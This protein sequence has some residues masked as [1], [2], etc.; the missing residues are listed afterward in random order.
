MVVQSVDWTVVLWA[1]YLVDRLAEKSVEQMVVSKGERL[2]VWR[3][4]EW[5]VEMVA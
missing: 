5:V 2:V 4:V 3:V 1:E